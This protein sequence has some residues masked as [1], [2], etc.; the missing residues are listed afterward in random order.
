MRRSLLARSRR[1]DGRAV[2]ARRLHRG[3]GPWHWARR[4]TA[5]GAF[6]AA[7]R[8]SQRVARSSERVR[9]GR[10]SGGRD[11]S[12]RLDSRV[13]LA[14][15]D[16]LMAKAPP[17]LPVEMLRRV[18]RIAKFDGIS[19]LA[20]AGLFALGSAA[21]GDFKGALIGIVI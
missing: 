17:L 18:V 9:L 16:T 5:G 13:G 1:G 8:R 3:P 7:T 14:F 10:P 4:R 6:S 2:Q 21:L 20:L 12:A 19:V 11:A 15:S